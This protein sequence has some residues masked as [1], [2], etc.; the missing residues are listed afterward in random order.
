MIYARG[1]RTTPEDSA[2]IER[3][4][5]EGASLGA[6]ARATGRSKQAVRMHLRA[7]ARDAED[8]PRRC[9]AL[10]AYKLDGQSVCQ[11]LRRGASGSRFCDQHRRKARRVGARLIPQIQPE[12]AHST[13]NDHA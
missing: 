7:L 8:P 12:R 13:G 6:I 5:V 1:Q 2:L 10:A 9:E 4:R 3:M 11:C